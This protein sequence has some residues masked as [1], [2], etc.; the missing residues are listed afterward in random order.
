M[1]IVFRESFSSLVKIRSDDATPVENF[2]LSDRELLTKD[3]AEDEDE[4][5]C[6]PSRRGRTAVWSLLACLVSCVDQSDCIFLTFVQS[7]LSVTG[8]GHHW[9]HLR[10][11]HRLR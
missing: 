5:L 9:C 4:G 2:S 7:G 3:K 10:H 1:K 6:S 11:C 8:G